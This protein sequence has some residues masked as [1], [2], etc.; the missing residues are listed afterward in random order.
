M[1]SL[2]K[3]NKYGKSSVKTNAQV[4]NKLIS[5]PRE[6]SHEKIDFGD[7]I[8]ELIFD[9][10]DIDKIMYKVLQPDQWEIQMKKINTKKQYISALILMSISLEHQNRCLDF[11]GTKTIIDSEDVACII[12]RSL[13]KKDDYM[14]ESSQTAIFGNKISY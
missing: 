11:L 13:S 7:K 14:I 6:E 9:L 8:S 3:I 1:S 10:F 12:R 2:N 4:W 5:M